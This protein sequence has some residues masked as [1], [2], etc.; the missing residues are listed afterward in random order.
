MPSLTRT[1]PNKLDHQ[2]TKSRNPSS[3]WQSC[4]HESSLLSTHLTNA[5]YPMAAD[6]DSCQ[7]SLASKPNPEQTYSRLQGS[8]PRSQNFLREVRPWKSGPVTETYRFILT[9]RCHNYELL[10]NAVQN[11][12]KKLRP[13]LRLQSLQRL[14]GCMSLPPM[15]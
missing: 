4:T 12:K 11:C 1:R 9:V 7:K 15:R 3:P 6:R 14:M 13:K 5:K 10:K 2:L 8:F